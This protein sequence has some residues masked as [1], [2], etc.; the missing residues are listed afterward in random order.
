MHVVLGGHEFVRIFVEGRQRHEF[1]G[2]GSLRGVGTSRQGFLHGVPRFIDFS[3]A[4]SRPRQIVQGRGIIC[5]LA[6]GFSQKAVGPGEI[7]TVVR[8]LSDKA[9]NLGISWRQLAR[10]FCV[11]ESFLL[12]L[13]RPS[14]E[15]R[16]FRCGGSQLGIHFQRLLEG[17]GRLVRCALFLVSFA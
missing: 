7:A 6:G 17:R 9:G 1:F 5:A 13:E 8:H 15:L 16:K 14:I 2:V 11:S 10:L 12:V 3:Q 4:I